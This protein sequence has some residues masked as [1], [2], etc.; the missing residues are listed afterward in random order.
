M[1]KILTQIIDCPKHVT[2]WLIVKDKATNFEFS[3]QLGAITAARNGSMETSITTLANGN[4]RMTYI[5]RF[6]T[7][8]DLDAYLAVLNQYAAERDAYNTANGVTYTATT[9]EE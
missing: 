4:L 3:N 6:P 7:Q 2:R 8:A 5:H 9:S 1:A